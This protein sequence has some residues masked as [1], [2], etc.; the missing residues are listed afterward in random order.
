MSFASH[1]YSPLLWY[2]IDGPHIVY[3]V[4]NRADNPEPG[5]EHFEFPSLQVIKYAGDG[6]GER[7][8]LVDRAEMKLFNQR[9]P[10][11]RERAGDK[12]RD[13]LSRLD[14]A[15]AP[16]A[17]IGPGEAAPTDWAR[18]ADGHQP[19]PRGSAGTSPRSPA[20]PTSTLAS[21]IR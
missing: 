2:N 21:A 20:C 14:W 3:K 1:V 12:A 8:L 6:M 11:A 13:L 16:D 7:G 18:P 5:G 19:R 10:A 9:F 4:V 15:A 17:S